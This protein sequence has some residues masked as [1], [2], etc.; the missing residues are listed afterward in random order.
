MN[1]KLIAAK[2]LT[3]KV[4]INTAFT[5]TE[6][7]VVISIVVVLTALLIPVVSKSRERALEAE[8]ANRLRSIGTAVH[9]FSNEHKG[10]IVTN[11]RE[12]PFGGGYGRAFFLLGPYIEPSLAGNAAALRALTVFRCPTHDSVKPVPGQL[13]HYGFSIIVTMR[14]QEGSGFNNVLPTP[15]PIASVVNPDNTPLSWSTAG[16][17]GGDMPYRPHPDAL[18]FGYNGPTSPNGM[19]PRHGPHCMVLFVSGRVAPVDVSDINNFPWNGNSPDRWPL[20]TVFDP[21]YYGN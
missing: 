9:M 1:N 4:E 12:S 11:G 7:I 3:A 13:H 5:L 17:A 19:A 6:L 14:N 15:L 21:L 2:K 16:E 18:K 8:S 20:N 10:Y